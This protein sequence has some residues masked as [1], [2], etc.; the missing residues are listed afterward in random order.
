M[1]T[2]IGKPYK[3]KKNKYIYRFFNVNINSM[4]LVWHRDKK[5]RW[6]KIINGFDWYLQM[7]NTIPFKLIKNQIYFIPKETFH[8]IIKGKSNLLIRIKEL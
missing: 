7:N 3:D 2:S 4:S 1:V 5:D 6:V 8:R